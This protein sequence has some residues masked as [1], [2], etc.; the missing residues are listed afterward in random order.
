M[1]VYLYVV[2][3]RRLYGQN[4]KNDHECEARVIRNI[5]HHEGGAV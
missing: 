2:Y 4:F 1:I 3:I 5:I